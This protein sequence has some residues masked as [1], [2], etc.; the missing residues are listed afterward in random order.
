MKQEEENNNKIR[1]KNIE[2]IKYW[3][4]GVEVEYF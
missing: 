2:E 3:K 4:G 1:I